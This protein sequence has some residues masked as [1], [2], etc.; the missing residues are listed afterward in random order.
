MRISKK[1]KSMDLIEFDLNSTRN[2]D[3]KSNR[4]IKLSS[5]YLKSFV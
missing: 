4:P 1:K 2:S 5:Q 3:R